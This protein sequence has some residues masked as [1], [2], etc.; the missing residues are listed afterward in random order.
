M[1]WGVCLRVE[2]DY[3]CFTRPEMK[4]ERVSYEVMTPSAARGVLEAVYWKP[5]IRWRVRRIQALKPIRFTNLR[6]NELGGKLAPGA[7]RK[8]MK[9]G[10][11]LRPSSRRTASSGGHDPQGRG[12]PDR[13]RIR[14][15]RPGGPEP[16]QAPGYLPPPGRAGPV[17]PAPYLG[18]RE[19]PA[20]FA[21]TR[22]RR[23]PARRSCGAGGTWGSCSW[24]WIT[25]TPATPSP[26]SSP[27]CWRTGCSPPGEAERR[28]SHDPP[29]P[30]RLL[31][32]PG[33]GPRRPVAAPASPT[34]R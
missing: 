23:R 31:P 20:R 6:R 34:P 13:R 8:A 32:T 29:G 15:H 19:F 25:R 33:R 3:A 5:A 18:C 21:C 1:A 26:A 28:P 16:G 11:P 30:Q 7:V 10:G 4:V 27:P 14:L 9:S 12:L 24:T 17:L 22:G 2:G